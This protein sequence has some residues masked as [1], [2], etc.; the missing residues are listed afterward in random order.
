MHITWQ[1]FYSSTLESSGLN[2]LDGFHIQI[3]NESFSPIRTLNFINSDST[4]TLELQDFQRTTL[5]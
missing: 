2:L 3:S 5:I 4:V 1:A